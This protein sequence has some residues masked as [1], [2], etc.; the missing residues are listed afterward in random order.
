MIAPE[1]TLNSLRSRLL[2]IVAGASLCAS[3][4]VV[5]AAEETEPAE[6]YL[7][8]QAQFASIESLDVTSRKVSVSGELQ[9]EFEWSFDSYRE[10]AGDY[11]HRVND[12]FLSFRMKGEYFRVSCSYEPW[13]EMDYAYDGEKYQTFDLKSRLL[14]LHE[15]EGALGSSH[16]LPYLI[17]PGVL[18]PFAFVF[19]ST[20]EPESFPTLRS[21][22]IWNRLA[23]VSRSMGEQVVD[24][25]RC[26]VVEITIRGHPFHGIDR[27][28]VYFAIETA[29]FPIRYERYIGDDIYQIFQAREIEEIS[30]CGRRE[31]DTEPYYFSRRS[32]LQTFDSMGSGRPTG[33]ELHEIDV[34]FVRVNVDIPDAF[35]TIAHSEALS[36]MDSRESD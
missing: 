17:T 18:Q 8:L 15:N 5:I 21:K 16:D 23:N 30:R 14:W 11:R 19:Y 26:A 33:G 10:R 36:V 2:T 29:Y 6:I 27:T 12:N 9:P 35:F 1:S 20:D 4:S 7:A 25:H 34:D 31:E 13:E 32:L 24:G 3:S 22:D 28:K